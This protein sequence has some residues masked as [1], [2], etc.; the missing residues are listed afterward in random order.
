MFHKHCE[1]RGELPLGTIHSAAWNSG[2]PLVQHILRQLSLT[3]TTCTVGETERKR[4]CVHLV[5]QPVPSG[6]GL[7]KYPDRMVCVCYGYVGFCC[8][9]CW[10]I[11]IFAVAVF[12][13]DLLSP[14]PCFVISL[15]FFLN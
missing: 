15:C 8:C 12:Q 3:L 13:V 4:P 5:S 6:C 11:G 7:Y 9:C 10:L 2:F 14:T 1:R